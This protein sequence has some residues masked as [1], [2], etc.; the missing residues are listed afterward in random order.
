[1]D[2]IAVG[3]LIA[4]L[5]GDVSGV[6][7][8]VRQRLL[9]ELSGA[10]HSEVPIVQCPTKEVL[11]G[12]SFRYESNQR[13]RESKIGIR[14]FIDALSEAGEDAYFSWYTKHDW[15]VMFFI[16]CEMQSILG[17]SITVPEAAAR[18]REENSKMELEFG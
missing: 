1:V 6:P 7:T 2:V 3:K 18:L 11:D 5:G 16:D 17:C 15:H 8:A 13:F 14:E 10:A 12:Y 9:D 4:L